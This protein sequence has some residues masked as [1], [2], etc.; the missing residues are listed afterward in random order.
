MKASKLS[1]VSGKS[2]LGRWRYLREKAA[3]AAL[4]P[5][6]MLAASPA[7]A[8]LPTVPTPGPAIGGGQVA[9]GDWLGA[10]GALFRAAITIF[11]LVIAAMGFLYVVSGALSKWRAYS[12]G[13]AEL[14]DLKEY[15][16]M[17]IVIATFLVMMVYHAIETLT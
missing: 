4:L 15:F 14:G 12:M 5:V 13:R 16:V 9:Q 8:G 1:S 2:M 6:V 11:G 17:G 10:A 3:R 7:F